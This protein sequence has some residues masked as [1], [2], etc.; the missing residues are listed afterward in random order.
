ML[1]PVSESVQIPS[2]VVIEIGRLS[3]VWSLLL[4]FVFCRVG[5]MRSD[6]LHVMTHGP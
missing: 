6:K 1:I 3:M 5:I 2:V 4:A